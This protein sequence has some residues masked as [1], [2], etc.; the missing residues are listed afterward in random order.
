MT[1]TQKPV[2]HQ[3]TKVE[4]EEEVKIDA[5]PDELAAA[6]MQGGAPRREADDKSLARGD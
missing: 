1:E 2:D 3:P 5:S 6:L 4:L